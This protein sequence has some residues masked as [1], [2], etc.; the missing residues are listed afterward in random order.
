MS[1]EPMIR[2][3][4]ARA[5][6]SESRIKPPQFGIVRWLNERK[7]IAPKAGKIGDYPD[8]VVRL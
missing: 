3:G 4:V 5:N 2:D 8:V 7:P 6:D 1:N